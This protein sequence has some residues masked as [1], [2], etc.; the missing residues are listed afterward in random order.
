MASTNK[1]IGTGAQGQDDA[2]S[3]MRDG[4][5][6]EDLQNLYVAMDLRSQAEFLRWYMDFIAK[7]PSIKEAMMSLHVSKGANR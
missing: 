3:K 2:G 6:T 7:T 1:I 4:T 5:T